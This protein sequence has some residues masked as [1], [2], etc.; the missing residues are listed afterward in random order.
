MAEPA[1]DDVVRALGRLLSWPEIARSAQLAKFLEYI[2]GRTLAGDSQSIKAYSIAVDVLGRPANFDPQTD[3][4]VRVQA[5]RL[6][7]LLEQYYQGPGALDEVRIG[8]PVGRY[9]PVFSEHG[10]PDKRPPS[11]E[12]HPVEEET[13]QHPGASE[14]SRLA[15]SWFALAVF[16]MTGALLAYAVSN[17]GDIDR[18]VA[19]VAGILDAPSVTVLEFQNLT[20]EPQ[21]GA[22]VAGLGVELVTALQ[23]FETIAVSYGGNGAGESNG[24]GANDY[25]LSGI[26][27]RDDG[28]LQFS[29]ILTEAV[30]RSVVWSLTVPVTTTIVPGDVLAQVSGAISRSLGSPRGPLHRTART[31]IAT[32]Q[33]AGG[34]ETLYL[35]EVMFDLYRERPAVAIGEQA[36][37]CFEALDLR[38]RASGRALASLGSLSAEAGSGAFTAGGDSPARL[39]DADVMLAQAIQ[40]SPVS[41]FVWEQRARVYE[42]LGQDQEAEAAFASALQLNPANTDAMAAWAR[43]LAFHG[44]L[45]EADHFSMQALA[46]AP[47]APDWYL[48]VPALLA[49]RN[50]TFAA[51]VEYA[52]RYAQADHELGPVLAVIAGQRLGDRDIVNAY[53]PRVLEVPEF[54]AMGIETRLGEMIS[55]PALLDTI[56]EAL[57]SAGVP[58]ASL[59]RAF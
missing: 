59:V 53:L 25:T 28:M 45:D 35:C 6:R 24:G 47:E 42:A 32:G 58:E 16:T 11:I 44:R 20:G 30:S 27:R 7:N 26:V 18:D 17:W 21:D 1:D 48:G 38:E 36:T 3:P 40:A 52:E 49:L 5:R 34:G 43:H 8:L 56:G 29:S 41:S 2:V 37:R 46:S 13:P 57:V 39:A 33:S 22:H 15:R 23:K 14:R 55:D 51:A 12:T 50:G 19:P 9:V 10:A 4:I 54:R 31:L